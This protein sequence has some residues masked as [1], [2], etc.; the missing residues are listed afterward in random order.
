[1]ISDK[2]N[3]IYIN[4]VVVKSKNVL[5][6][7]LVYLKNAFGWVGNDFVDFTVSYTNQYDDTGPILFV[8]I[9]TNFYLNKERLFNPFD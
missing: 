6:K 4:D 1:M 7:N 9:L 3:K 5:E 2:K 8:G